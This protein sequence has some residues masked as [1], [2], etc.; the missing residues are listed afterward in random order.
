MGNKGNTEY[1]CYERGREKQE[2]DLLLEKGSMHKE[3]GTCG[4][5]NTKDAWKSLRRC[6]ALH[7]PKI[8]ICVSIQAWDC[9]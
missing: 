4:T 5:N 3:R 9:W 2:G 8:T 1:R 6:I 7:L